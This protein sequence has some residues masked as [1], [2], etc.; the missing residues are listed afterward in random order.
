[1]S[2]STKITYNLLHNEDQS[3]VTVFVPGQP[4][5]SA[6]DTHPRFEDAVALLDES[7][8]SYKNG[9]AEDGWDLAFEAYELI[10]VEAAIARRF[11]KLSDRVS[12]H[13]G[14]VFLDGDEV[15]GPLLDQILKQFESGEDFKPLVNFYERLLTNPLGHAKEALYPW[16]QANPVSITP[17]GLV[18][19]YKV[20]TKHTDDETGEIYS[21]PTRNDGGGVV[22][23]VEFEPGEW[24]R[25]VPGSRVEM[26][27]SIVLHEPSAACGEG[28]HVGNWAY[29]SWFY[30]HGDVTLE[31]HFDPRDVVNVPNSDNKLRVCRYDVVG[32]ITEP[33]TDSVVYPDGPDE[34][35]EPD[36]GWLGDDKINSGPTAD[37]LG[38]AF[39]IVRDTLG[40]FGQGNPGRPNSQR[41]SN[42]RFTG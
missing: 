12:V 2:P 11:D 40:R 5:R 1:M 17:E 16:M 14:R 24:L 8:Q 19:A 10:D 31:V 22:D 27:R 29:K 28:L 18:I 3:V 39:D 30:S 25:Q 26:S 37:D 20:M 9:D 36:T 38:I 35:F 23:G 13:S 41:G 15:T 34:D 21:T 42:G 4:M 6:G 7:R 33:Y 32:E